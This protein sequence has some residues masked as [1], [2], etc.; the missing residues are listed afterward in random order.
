MPCGL[1]GTE[2]QEEAG[3]VPG[4]QV[5]ALEAFGVGD[6][7]DGGRDDGHVEGDKEDA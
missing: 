3:A 4:N 2:S 1:E 6:F 7:G 5:E